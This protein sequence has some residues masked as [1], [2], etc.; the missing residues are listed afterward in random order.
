M[1]VV[2]DPT[3]RLL[4]DALLA[5]G[6]GLFIGL[7][8]EQSDVSGVPP[9]AHTGTR[10]ETSLGVR[11]FAL[12]ALFGW[13]SAYSQ[14]AHPWLPVA[15]LGVA[16]GLVVLAAHREREHGGGL[17]TEVAALTTLILGMLVHHQR[18]IAVAL[19]L[20]TTLLLISKPWFRALVP[21]MRRVDLTSTLQLL[22]LLAIVLP[23]L[24]EEARDPWRVLSPRRIG[25]FVALIAGI[26]YLGYV[27]NRLLGGRRGAGLT[28]FVG[29]LVSSTAVTVAMAQHA[30]VA[31]AMVLPGQFATLI[32]NT[33]MLVR[34]LVVS[35][36]INATVTRSLALPL[37]SMA[38]CM[39]VGVLWKWRALRLTDP[40][41]S[42][43]GE[44]E[45]KNPFSLVPALK[46]GV[47]F[48][49]ILVASAVA[50]TTFGDS[51]FVAMAA[52]SGFMDVDAV[53][54]T[55]T[56]LAG[57]GEIGMDV[58]ALSIT[59]AVV[60]NTVVKGV[61]AWASGARRFGA[62]IAK[63]FGSAIVVGLLVAVGQALR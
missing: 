2:N 4:I 36:L 32:A 5:I 60:S 42:K 23:L 45:L 47:L 15:A 55:A 20:A 19:A 17:T 34:V 11:T 1:P 18:A 49:A 62:D 13:V 10:Q 63:V 30:R 7:E 12:L 46:W 53:T 38:V 48:A 22:I 9:E 27:V 39:M 41:S 28:G 31:G 14:E 40:E 61:I 16:G 54:L 26:G 50:R 6:I 29:G 21:R 3:T 8:R 56:R 43:A 33:V 25:V 52:V 58:A 59:V 51:G 44:L 24:P 37:G 57:G 35:A